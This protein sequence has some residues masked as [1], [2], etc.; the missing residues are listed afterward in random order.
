MVT[1]LQHSL[2]QNEYGSEGNDDDE[3]VDPGVGEGYQKVDVG[4]SG[5]NR[6]MSVVTKDGI[7]WDDTKAN[8]TRP[9]DYM[10][11]DDLE[12]EQ[13]MRSESVHS[14]S[15]RGGS[16]RQRSEASEAS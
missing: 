14:A 6:K 4:G 13:R 10:E 16:H 5:N 12:D 8:I 7:L 15:E 11:L 3:F 2:H 1:S 9:T